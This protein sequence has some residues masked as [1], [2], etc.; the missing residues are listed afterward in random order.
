MANIKKGKSRG[1]AT[2]TAFVRINWINSQGEIMNTN[3]LNFN[4]GGAHG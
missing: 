4:N 3:K 2:P 1:A